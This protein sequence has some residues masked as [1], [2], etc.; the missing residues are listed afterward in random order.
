M[1]S[2]LEYIALFLC[3]LQRNSTEHLN[4]W[5][6]LHHHDHVMS[7]LGVMTA[8]P[9]GFYEITEHMNCESLF[10]FG[11]EESTRS[12]NVHFLNTSHVLL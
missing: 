6:Q 11:I 10:F 8:G 12:L 2:V 5:I 7:L 9:D 3:G 4:M 1:S